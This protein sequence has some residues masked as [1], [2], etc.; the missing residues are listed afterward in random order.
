MWKRLFKEPFTKITE[1]VL[2]RWWI[3]AVIEQ[4]LPNL[5]KWAE[6]SLKCA[7]SYPEIA[8]PNQRVLETTLLLSESAIKA[9]LHWIDMFH[10]SW[11]KQY[12]VRLS[13][14]DET[15][16]DSLSRSHHMVVYTL[17]MGQ[18]LQRLVET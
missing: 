8:A 1:P 16:G 18:E 2:T 13:A 10:K 3:G 15:S 17:V 5:E 14:V 11:W 6:I 9:Q 12:F 4:V 7:N